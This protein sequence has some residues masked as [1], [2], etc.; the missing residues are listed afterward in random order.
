M[1][2]AVN[3]V[4]SPGGK[5][6][7]YDPGALE[8]AWNERVVCESARGLMVARVVTAN[9]EVS[10]QR[11]REPLRRVLRRVT[12]EDDATEQVHKKRGRE[13]LL[14]MRDLLRERHIE[15]ARPIAAD[16]TLDGERITISYRAEERVELRGLQ[17][18]LSHRLGARVD[19]RRVAAREAPV[20][21][22]ARP[23]PPR[24]PWCGS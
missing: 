5:V 17:S 1:P 21:D 23:L 19:L 10:L 9:H 2:V 6:S 16:I 4:F 12:S 15:N 18:P 3:V 11:R 24:P 7:P 14:A 22:L 13:A 8:L 20:H